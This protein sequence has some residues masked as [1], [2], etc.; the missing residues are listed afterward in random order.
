MSAPHGLVPNTRVL[1]II[2]GPPWTMADWQPVNFAGSAAPP[3]LLIHGQADQT[4]DPRNSET[5]A[6]AL[7]ARGVDVTLRMMPRLSHSDTIAAFSVP[8]RRRAPVL[9]ETVAFVQRWSAN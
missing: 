9:D 8:L 3:A 1:N 6:A 5:L 7:R 4:V 2:F